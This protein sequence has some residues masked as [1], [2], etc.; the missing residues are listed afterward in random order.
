MTLT[1]HTTTQTVTL[2]GALATV[3]SAVAFTVLSAHRLQLYPG[4]ES[5]LAVL[6]S[7]AI[8]ALRR[9]L[10]QRRAA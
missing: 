3:V 2:A 4:V 6:F 5:A 8:A 10:A 1:E 9:R 7:V